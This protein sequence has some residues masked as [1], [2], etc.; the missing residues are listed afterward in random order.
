MNEWPEV[1]ALVITYR[2]KELALREIAS[3]KE[4]LDYPNLTWH[5]ADDGSGGDYIH[6]LC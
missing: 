2:R 5:I 1:V 4:F 3:I 6:D